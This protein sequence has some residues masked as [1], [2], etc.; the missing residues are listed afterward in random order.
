MTNK[1]QLKAAAISIAAGIFTATGT[2]T[3]ETINIA[4]AISTDI[5]FAEVISGETSNTTVITAKVI[6]SGGGCLVLT[7]QTALGTSAK[8]SYNVMRAA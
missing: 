8:I 1:A 6:P 2:G 5:P 3:T 4:A 7:A